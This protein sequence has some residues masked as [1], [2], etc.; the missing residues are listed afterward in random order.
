MQ[1]LR[2]APSGLRHGRPGSHARLR[3]GAH[4]VFSAVLGVVMLSTSALMSPASALA[5]TVDGAQ[6]ASKRLSAGDS[7]SLAIS[8]DARVLAWGDNFYNQCDVPSGLDD[9]VAVAAGYTHS[10]ALRSDGTVAE[11]GGESG[12]TYVPPNTTDAIAIAAGYN[13]SLVVSENGTV[14]AAGDNN[15]GK[16]DVPPGLSGVVAVSAGYDHSL[17]LR[18]NGTVVAWG[19]NAWGQCNVPA[20]LNNVV[21]VVAGGL[22]S[23]ALRSDGTVVAWGRSSEKQCAVPTGLS[24]VVQIAAGLRH[25]LALKSDGTVVAWGG[26]TQLFTDASVSVPAGLTNAVAVSAGGQHSL[27]VLPDGS[28]AAWGANGSGQAFGTTSVEPLPWSTD[29]SVNGTFTVSFSAPIQ[30]GSTYAQ[31]AVKDAAGNPVVIDKSVSGNQLRIKPKSPLRSSARYTVLV[32]ASAVKDSWG[33]ANIGTSFDYTTPDMA[34]PVVVSVN[35]SDGSQV[36]A[37]DLV[38]SMMFDEGLV[39]G[40]T[41]ADVALRDAQGTVVP[42][43]VTIGGSGNRVL[44]VTPISDVKRPGSYRLTVPADAVQDTRGNRFAGKSIAFEAMPVASRLTFSAPWRMPYASS[45]VH[46]YLKDAS[47]IP[48]R[49]RPVLIQDASAGWTTVATVYTDANG[50]FV[51]T[52]A[53]KITTTYRAYFAGDATYKAAASASRTVLTVARPRPLTPTR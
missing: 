41:F 50:R 12:L 28:F 3:P 27:A 38:L 15:A 31:V 52:I 16:C 22:H 48:V 14:T 2:T 21:A 32:P 6:L 40:P 29:I 11:W 18:S 7:H 33:N 30:P 43:T 1:R 44:S 17:A 53:P 26:V 4:R 20:G 10:L 47:G 24:N 34:P 39:P 8:P 42:C 19:S 35:P 49:N 9:V 36:A 13:H 37:A 51:A 46:G 23:L 5:L 45:K 25:S